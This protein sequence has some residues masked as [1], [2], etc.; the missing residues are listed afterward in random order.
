MISLVIFNQRSFKKIMDKLKNLLAVSSKQK[1]SSNS[2]LK[3]AEKTDL[4]KAIKDESQSIK[5]PDLEKNKEVDSQL[6]DTLLQKRELESYQEI[7][8]KTKKDLLAK[9]KPA[10]EASSKEEIPSSWDYALSNTY[11][12]SFEER[13]SR[14]AEQLSSQ[15][16]I[17]KKFPY[18]SDVHYNDRCQDLQTF[19]LSSIELLEERVEPEFYS[20]LKKDLSPLMYFLNTF[21]LSKDVLEPLFQAAHFCKLNRFDLAEDKYIELAV[22]NK[23]WT[24]GIPILGLHERTGTSRIFSSYMLHHMN[25]PVHKKFILAFKRMMTKL[26]ELADL[27]KKNN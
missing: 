10:N 26:K 21:K 17:I 1:V 9:I 4:N 5:I 8:E 11:L 23:A 3:V 6:S 24:L 14:F 7:Y 22:G 12:D 15:K 25:E 2:T 19:I 13:N 18:L 27:P 20:A 16:E